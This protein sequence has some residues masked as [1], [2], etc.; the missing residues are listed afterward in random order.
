SVGGG[1]VVGG[2]SSVGGGAAG[3]VGGTKTVDSSPLPKP[4][5]S[6]SSLGHYPCCNRVVCRFDPTDSDLGCQW[7]DH[8]VN[9]SCDLFRNL[10]AHRDIICVSYDNPPHIG[11]L[12]PCKADVFSNE[13]RL[14]LTIPCFSGIFHHGNSVSEEDI[15]AGRSRPGSRQRQQQQQAVERWEPYYDGVLSSQDGGESDDEIGDNEVMKAPKNQVRVNPGNPTQNLVFGAPDFQPKSL[16]NCQRS[17]RHN[18]DAQRQEDQRRMREMVLYLTKL[19]LDPTEKV[20]KTKKE[21]P[22]GTFSRIESQWRN[23]ILPSIKTLNQPFARAK[24]RFGPIK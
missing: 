9:G 15:K 14:T 11:G 13:D 5:S 10:I 21:Y 2:V 1:A 7:R 23:S 24:F 22:A 6:P 8:I 16:W 12:I 4:T 18:Q 19:R 17:I 20:E 3:A